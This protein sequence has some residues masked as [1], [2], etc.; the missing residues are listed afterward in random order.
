MCVVTASHSLTS[1]TQHKHSSAWF[2]H[3][4]CVLWQNVLGSHRTPTLSTL[5]SPPS[6]IPHRSAFAMPPCRAP[7]P[8]YLCTALTL[9]LAIACLA[10]ALDSGWFLADFGQS[11]DE[12]CSPALGRAPCHLKSLQ[13]IDEPYY[14]ERIK[15]ELGA[16][17]FAC[18]WN[19]TEQTRTDGPC[20][21]ASSAQ[22][23][24]AS[25]TTT[26]A[27]R[28]LSLTAARVCCCSAT[29]CTTSLEPVLREW[30]KFVPNI[31]PPIGYIPL[32]GF[33]HLP[34]SSVLFSSLAF[35][36]AGTLWISRYG[37]CSAHCV[38][39]CPSTSSFCSKAGFQVYLSISV[40]G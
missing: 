38:L 3:Q 11:C 6:H 8:L 28:P 39:F 22:C 2:V 21:D 36:L 37:A 4:V 40:R 1:I 19:S 29:G 12:T 31:K 5:T 14:L 34:G 35:C 15:L 32:D 16:H 23:F 24:L 7:S 26:C 20:M 18:P 13:A 33:V 9:L 27:T 10:S 17:A 30:R 25:P